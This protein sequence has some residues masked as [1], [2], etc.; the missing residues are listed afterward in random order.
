MNNNSTKK[1]ISSSDT[2]HNLQKSSTL[3]RRYVKKPQPFISQSD[4]IVKNDQISVKI[5]SVAKSQAEILKRRQVLAEKINKEKL[6][7][8]RKFQASKTPVNLENVV[9]E[10]SLNTVNSS[11]SPTRSSKSNSPITPP[12]PLSITMPAIATRLQRPSSPIKQLSSKELKDQAIKKALNS[13]SEPESPEPKLKKTKLFKKSP[14]LSET[15]KKSGKVKR[16]FI[17]FSCATACILALTYMIYTNIPGLPVKV[18]A[19]QSGIEA[20][21]PSYIPQGFQLTSVSA[22]KNKAISITFSNQDKQ[23]FVL[24]EEKS[25][26]DSSALLYNYV[27][28]AYEENYSIIREQGI[29]IYISKSDASWVNSGTLYKITSSTPELLSK[30]QIKDI[31]TSL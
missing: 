25:S 19:I 1:R 20:N 9:P 24:T 8:L 29:T 5:D 12:V 26:W 11:M 17:A 21:Y 23:S 31:A 15:F 18:T 6:K 27:K 16:I 2:H 4:K 28:S 10:L 22:T 3:N 30:N 13:I 14:K 7:H